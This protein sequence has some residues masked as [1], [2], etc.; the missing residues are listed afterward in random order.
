MQLGADDRVR[1][2]PSFPPCPPPSVSKHLA[3][4]PFSGTSGSGVQVVV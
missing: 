3:D 2:I 1:E 4:I